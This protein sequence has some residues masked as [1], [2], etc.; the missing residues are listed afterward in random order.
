MATTWSWNDQY[1]FNSHSKTEKL[2]SW[3]D[4]VEKNMALSE[5]VVVQQSGLPKMFGGNTPG[6]ILIEVIII[7]SKFKWQGLVYQKNQ[8]KK[9]V[10]SKITEPLTKN[11]A[12]LLKGRYQELSFGQGLF[13]VYWVSE[14]V[15]YVR[16]YWYCCSKT[17][18]TQFNLLK[19][20]NLLYHMSLIF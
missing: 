4:F 10:K 11:A 8:M 16:R 9:V 5:L 17:V 19:K 3:Q 2:H 18:D 14:H 15:F 1:S 20:N 6:F 12:T 13:Y 7:I